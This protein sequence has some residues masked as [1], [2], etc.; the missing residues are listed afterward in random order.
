MVNLTGAS[1]YTNYYNRK[2]ASGYAGY[3]FRYTLSGVDNSCED[4][5]WRIWI[6]AN[7]DKE[8]DSS[9]LVFEKVDKM[10]IYG[11]F[12]LPSN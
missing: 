10:S 5:Y 2:V 8:F 7:N 12:K 9:E 1:S 11:Y 3:S 6:D 4:L